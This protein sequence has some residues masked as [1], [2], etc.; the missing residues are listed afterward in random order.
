MHTSIRRLHFSTSARTG[1]F[2]F[3]D[4]QKLAEMGVNTFNAVSETAIAIKD[5]LAEDDDD[6]EEL[7][8]SQVLPG[9]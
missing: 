2:S 7:Q 9:G 3:I 4:G 1:L 5:L 6:F 8:R